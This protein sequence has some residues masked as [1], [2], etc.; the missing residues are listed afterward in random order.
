MLK[1][2]TM[3]ATWLTYDV[4][5]LTRETKFADAIHFF[6][7]DT[8]KIFVLTA[9]IIFTMGLFRRNLSKEKVRDYLNGKPKWFAYLLAVILGWITPF[10]SCSSIPLFI[11]FVSA[12]IPLGITM[13]FLAVSPM[14]I[15]AVAILGTTIGFNLSM[16]YMVVCGIAGVGFGILTDKLGW[17]KYIEGYGREEKKVKCC[18]GS[19]CKIDPKQKKITFK[20]RLGDAIYDTKDILKTIWLWVLFGIMA[21]SLLHGYVPED[22]FIKYASSNT[23]LSVPFAVILGIPLY[24]NATGVI[25]LMEALFL[26]GVPLGTVLTFMMS[27]T[28][29]S[30]PQMIILRKVVKKSLIIR[31]TAF[32]AISFIVIGILFNLLTL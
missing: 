11:G 4:F 10:C 6:I 13:T 14:P 32:L 15:E 30:L 5:E 2:F 24:S 19:E 16:L 1:V 28:A 12:G 7:E 3:L 22:F 26:K 31:F 9:L 18:C 29:L 25:P 20:D 8:S 17:D 21:G 23:F 27:I